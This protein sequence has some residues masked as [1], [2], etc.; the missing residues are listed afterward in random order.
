MLSLDY[1][2]QIIIFFLWVRFPRWSPFVH[3]MEHS[4]PCWTFSLTVFDWRDETYELQQKWKRCRKSES[5]HFLFADSCEKVSCYDVWLKS[6]SVK[7][8]SLP[9]ARGFQLR[10][11][12]GCG[13]HG[14]AACAGI[15]VGLQ[16]CWILF[17]CNTMSKWPSKW[18]T[19]MTVHSSWKVFF[20][21]GIWGWYLLN[22][23]SKRWVSFRSLR[24]KECLGVS[25]QNIPK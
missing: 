23:P 11:V 25:A 19:S 14:E 4:V 16:V 8:A 3:G 10:A 1:F 20:L 2:V 15:R 24:L 13:G 6:C 18:P 21:V 5:E 9:T 7:F 17:A 12:G 22:V